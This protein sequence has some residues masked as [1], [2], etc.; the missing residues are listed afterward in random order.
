MMNKIKFEELAV[1]F[2]EKLFKTLADSKIEIAP[3]WDI[4]HLC[5]RVDSLDRYEELKTQ[6]LTFGHLLI[7]SDVNG[8][9]IATFKLNSPIVFKEWSIDVVELPAPKPSKPTKEGFEHIEVVCD[10]SFSD[11]EIKYKHLKLD[12]GGLKKDFNQEFEVDLGERNLK[13]HH[14][15]LES[16]IRVEENKK[17]F[18]ALEESKI[19]KN[20]KKYMPFVAGTFPL[21]VY[22]EQSDLDILMYATDLNELSS[23][24]K[25]EYGH[26]EGFTSE[27][28]SVDGL[29][30]LIVNFN[31]YKVP[32]EIFAQ[33]KVVPK[34]KAYL[35]FQIEERLLKL[36]GEK[37]KKTVIE[38]RKNGLKTEPAF[39]T[40][41]GIKVDAY[42]ELLLL[43]KVADSQ[44]RKFLES[45]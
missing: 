16:V 29:E 10:E 31:L 42:N 41:L 6:F 18:G 11:L 8:R 25:R 36:G 17:I 39:A 7:E 14:M 21:G 34:Q 38:K 15:S 33:D 22:T 35:H 45:I 32:F 28:L 27:Q 24:L 9:P 43:Q 2:L 23:E 12:L 44:L 20:F 3:H 30:T 26:L 19:L 40:G 13:F 37:L 5:Y 4:D 1:E